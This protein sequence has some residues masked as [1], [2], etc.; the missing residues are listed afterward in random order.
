MNYSN[1]CL[2]TKKS[3]IGNKEDLAKITASKIAP[4]FYNIIQLGPRMILRGVFNLMRANIITRLISVIVLLVFDIYNL[5]KNKISKN[6]FIINVIL[7]FSLLVGGTIGWTGGQYAV[8]VL[9]E[10]IALAILGGVI[11]AGVLAGLFGGIIEKIISKFIKSDFE[12]MLAIYNKEFVNLCK[13]YNINRFE[14]SNLFEMITITPYDLKTLFLRE[15]REI[16]AYNYL[17][18]YFVIVKEHN[19]NS[20]RC[21][22]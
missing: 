11:G 8:N 15:N 20:N 6:Q 21:I 1:I 18:K 12:E 13:E 2:K 4:M 9:V 22:K 3:K 19:R 16:C 17:E 7:A 14:L 10:N 5:S